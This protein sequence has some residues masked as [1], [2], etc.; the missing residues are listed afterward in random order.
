MAAPNPVFFSSE[1]AS[2]KALRRAVRSTRVRFPSGAS[3]PRSYR[4]PR[5]SSPSRRPSRPPHFSPS[6]Q[7]LVLP[8]V[9]LEFARAVNKTRRQSNCPLG[10]KKINSP[11]PRKIRGPRPAFAPPK[12]SPPPL[13]APNQP[14]SSPVPLHVPHRRV[15]I[16]IFRAPAPRAFVVRSPRGR[17]EIGSRR[18]RP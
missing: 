3:R 9:S 12:P 14:S 8:R 13:C 15:S 5:A 18:I 11:S 6:P 1:S 2:A 16:R 4:T 17:R 10:N 7:P